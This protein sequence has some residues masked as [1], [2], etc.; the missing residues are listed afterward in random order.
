MTQ[1]KYD[2]DKAMNQPQ[3]RE[4]I[5]HLLKSEHGAVYAQ[6]TVTGALR[7]AAH[8][9]SVEEADRAYVD[10]ALECMPTYCKPNRMREKLEACREARAREAAESESE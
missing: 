2:L 10:A 5:E 6:D 9:Q 4:I 8:V 7:A 3:A 1:P